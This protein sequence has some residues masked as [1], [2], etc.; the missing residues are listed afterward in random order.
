MNVKY[1]DETLK[2]IVQTSL[3]A[4]ER[5][6]QVNYV[7]PYKLSLGEEVPVK[8]YNNLLYTIGCGKYIYPSLERGEIIAAVCTSNGKQGLVFSLRG[9]YYRKDSVFCE[10]SYTKYEDCKRISSIPELDSDE[11]FSKKELEE[12]FKMFC[13]IFQIASLDGQQKCLNFCKKVRNSKDYFGEDRERI[14]QIN[15][16]IQS[17]WDADY[18]GRYNKLG[19]FNF[20]GKR[21]ITR[22]WREHKQKIDSLIEAKNR[23]GELNEKKIVI[24]REVILYS[25]EI[26]YFLE[27]SFDKQYIYTESEDIRQKVL[28]SGIEYWQKEIK[29]VDSKDLVALIDLSVGDC[30]DAILFKVNEVLIRLGGNYRNVY[31]ELKG[32]YLGF[33]KVQFNKKFDFHK[34]NYV[35]D[36][37]HRITEENI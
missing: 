33:S 7:K 24:I 34:L 9:I 30:S 26:K 2:L 8:L 23:K 5:I 36:K 18:R 14:D 12:M 31:Y 4:C 35:L 15:D 10:S 21:K 6:S 29:Y 16:C 22:E 28:E 32:C 1:S 17:F 20:I 13:H 37:I 25:L 11:K 27:K 3:T 19:L